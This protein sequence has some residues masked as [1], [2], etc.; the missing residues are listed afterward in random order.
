MTNDLKPRQ[1]K[2]IPI[3]GEFAAYK[4]NEPGFALNVAR[5]RQSMAE[6]RELLRSNSFV[7]ASTLQAV[8]A[9][10]TTDHRAEWWD[11]NMVA[12]EY[13]TPGKG[14]PQMPDDYTPAQTGGQAM[15]G[16]RRTHRMNYHNRDIS[17]RMPS[18][19]AIK[20]YSAEHGNP[21]FDVPVSVAVQGGQPRQGWVRVTKT[22][23]NNW[24]ATALG[25]SSAAADQLSEAVASV[26]EARRPSVALTRVAD[27]LE[28]KRQR[29][30]AKGAEMAPVS[31]HFIEEIGYDEASGTMAT[32]IGNKLYGHHVSK[33]LFEAVKDSPRP[34]TVF[35]QKVKSNPGAGV[36]RCTKCARFYSAAVAHVCPTSHKPEAGIGLDY[37]EKAKKRAEQVAARA[38]HGVDP[39]LAKNVVQPPP[40]V[41]TAPSPHAQPV[42]LKKTGVPGR[43]AAVA[44]SGLG[45]AQH[46]P[47]HLRTPIRSQTDYAA[48]IA[49]LKASARAQGYDFLGNRPEARAEVS[50]NTATYNAWIAANAD[51]TLQRF[52]NGQPVEAYGAE[53]RK[54][55]EM[56][57]WATRNAL[58]MAR[59]TDAEEYIRSMRAARS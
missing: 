48:E 28:K 29:E 33:A 54:A 13:R 25:G 53:H 50:C 55:Q 3:G 1:P 46:V 42:P 14:Y 38:S 4:H 36:D 24:E 57:Q 43:P 26:L 32:R 40:P 37:V 19:T 16:N 12:A 58:G 31:S 59:V 2:G 7:P 41:N 18:A 52:L 39:T 44:F 5:H 22:G 20:R 8:A 17:V 35:N 51:G 15:S 30:Q 56:E 11:T 10:T 47:V 45:A 34:G 23:P 9:P 27:L 21:T 6:R 49:P